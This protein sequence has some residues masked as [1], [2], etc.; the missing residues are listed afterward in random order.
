MR[1]TQALL[2]LTALVCCSEAFWRL[3]CRG[4]SGLGLIDPIM[5]SGRVS[6]HSH[7]IQGPSNFGL[8]A[9]GSSMMVRDLPY[10][11]A[12]KH[13]NRCSNLIVRRVV[14]NKI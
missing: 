5:D 7:T 4:R 3:P 6:S 13:A 12:F 8:S 2:P 14:Y 1:Y 9:N 10:R 11:P